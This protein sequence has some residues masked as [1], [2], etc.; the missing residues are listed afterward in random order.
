MP[1]G[2]RYNSAGIVGWR[3]YTG[4]IF[5]GTCTTVIITKIWCVN[6]GGYLSFGFIVG[7]DSYCICPPT[8]LVV[9]TV[10]GRQLL[11]VVG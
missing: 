2:C 10:P 6:V 8:P 9:T 4:T 11:V 1:V 5:R 3:I 7:S